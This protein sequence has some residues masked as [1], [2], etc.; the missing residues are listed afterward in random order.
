MIR[1]FDYKIVPV[2]HF[3]IQFKKNFDMVLFLYWTAP[4]Q[5]KFLA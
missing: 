4:F 2:Q 1:K 5:Q 3:L